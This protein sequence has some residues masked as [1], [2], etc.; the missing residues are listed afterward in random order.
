MRI[1]SGVRLRLGPDEGKQTQSGD[2]PHPHNTVVMADGAATP[3]KLIE[4]E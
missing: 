1:I 2:V 3:A 4:F